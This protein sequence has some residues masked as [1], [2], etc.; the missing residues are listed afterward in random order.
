MISAKLVREVD[1]TGLGVLEE[2][3]DEKHNFFFFLFTFAILGRRKYSIRGSP[4]C[5][6]QGQTFQSFKKQRHKVQSLKKNVVFYFKQLS[7]L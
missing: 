7:V 1:D 4:C 2:N 3:M 5:N 6:E